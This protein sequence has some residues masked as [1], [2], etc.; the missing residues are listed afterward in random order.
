LQ[1][2]C[3]E[4]RSRQRRSGLGSIRRSYRRSFCMSSTR[5]NGFKF[6]AERRIRQPGA[7]VDQGYRRD[8]WLHLRIRGCHHTNFQIVVLWAIWVQLIRWLRLFS[9]RMAIWAR[10]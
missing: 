7:V 1:V 3:R 10:I 8:L 2:R 4:G 9:I 5:M 6:N